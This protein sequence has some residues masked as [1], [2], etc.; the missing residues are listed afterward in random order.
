MKGKK[1]ARNIYKLLGTTVIGGVATSKS[2]SDSTVLWHMQLGHIGERGMMELHKRNLLKG[3]EIC[4][5]DLCK[6]CVFGKQNKVQFKT[7]THK[8]KKF[9]DY[10][11]TDVWGPMRVVSLGGNMYF[12]SF[13][14][15]YSRKVWVYFMRHKSDTFAK[16]KLWKTE[17]ENQIERK[18]KMPQVK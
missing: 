1:L 3:I 9:L 11:H 5:L 10:V 7:A 12:V 4:K 6:Y 14:D 8:T 13:I 16:F 2:E 18:I 17:V 15:Y